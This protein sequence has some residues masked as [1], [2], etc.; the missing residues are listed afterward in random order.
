MHMQK[1]DIASLVVYVFSLVLML[2][3]E[4]DI[5]SLVVY[6]FRQRICGFDLLRS[7]KG[8]VVV[9]DVNGWSFVKNSTKYYDDAAGIIRKQV[10]RVV[11]NT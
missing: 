9:C 11:Q 2:I 3:Q 4:K 6:A 8:R 1:K 5:A 7:E 10:P